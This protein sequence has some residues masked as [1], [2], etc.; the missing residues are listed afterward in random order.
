MEQTISINFE[1]RL[2]R[3]MLEEETLFLVYYSP[4]MAAIKAKAF[5]TGWWSSGSL[6][7][8]PVIN[9]RPWHIFTGIYA[10]A[11]GHGF[12]RTGSRTLLPLLPCYLIFIG[13]FKRNE[14]ILTCLNKPIVS[15]LFNSFLINHFTR[16]QL[17]KYYLRIFT[18]ILLI[19]RM[20]IKIT[21][22]KKIYKYQIRRYVIFFLQKHRINMVFIF[23]SIQEIAKYNKHTFSKRHPVYKFIRAWIY[24]QLCHCCNISNASRVTL[25][26]TRLI[27][28]RRSAVKFSSLAAV[29]ADAAA[30]S[31]V[32][33]RFHSGNCCLEIR[34]RREQEGTFTS[35]AAGPG[36]FPSTPA[37]WFI[38]DLRHWKAVVER[39]ESGIEG[40]SRRTGSQP[41]LVFTVNAVPLWFPRFSMISCANNRIG[42]DE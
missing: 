25:N 2:I 16:K 6:S 22:V 18:K 15:I 32:I 5:S 31:N 3:E 4:I 28:A 33:A 1:T 7:Q 12:V 40:L 29:T 9:H 34:T 26:Y 30:C 37:G 23:L 38:F 24:I 11:H 14:F 10:S 17:W 39:E 20:P 42:I 36:R 19:T 13:H 21:R 8:N 41:F 35:T 27:H